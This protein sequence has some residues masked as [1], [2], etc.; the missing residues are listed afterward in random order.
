MTIHEQI[1]ALLNGELTDTRQVSELLHVL[2]VSPEKRDLL[3]EQVR[4]S[5]GF[6]AMGGSI[7]PPPAVDAKILSGL[8]AIDAEFP[9]VG[10]ATAVAPSAPAVGGVAG[11]AA[12]GLT[13][14]FLLRS[15]AA[16]VLV[17]VGL[18][19]GYMAGQRGDSDAVVAMQAKLKDASTATILLRDSLRDE[20]AELA[21]LKSGQT[22]TVAMLDSL[23]A[24]ASAAPRV[25]EV[26]RYIHTAAPKSSLTEPSRNIEQPAVTPQ[27]SQPTSTATIAQATEL[28]PAQIDVPRVIVEQTSVPVVMPLLRS[29]APVQDAATTRGSRRLQIGLRNHAVRVSLPKVYG[30]NASQNVLTGNELFASYRFSEDG[31]VKVGAAAG[32]TR[33]G[34]VI[35]SNTGGTPVDTITELN[36]DLFYGRAFLSSEVLRIP[37]WNTS[38]ALELG[39]GGTEIG[40]MGTFGLNAE[41]EL[42]DRLSFQFGTSSWLLLA[43]YRG[44]MQSS[45][46]FNGHLGVAYR[47]F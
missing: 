20:R 30:L 47:L 4:M 46:N 26:V 24:A 21:S 41:I 13:A 38:L 3:V 18:G 1:T 29:S 45:V 27:N 19:I 44:R 36:P 8:A 28:R 14:S 11:P 35:H 25:R 7:A 15:F 5:R 39:A 33:I 2:A 31:G 42:M 34:L 17:G 32:R 40:P 9:S 23:R 16:L 37:E 43:T 6:A 10:P 22:A 12:G